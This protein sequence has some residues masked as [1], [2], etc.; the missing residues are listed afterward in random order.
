[1]K[2]P[3][4][5]YQTPLVALLISSVILI[6]SWKK[7]DEKGRTWATYKGDEKSTSYAPLDQINTSNVT[8]LQ[9][10]WTFQINDVP[11]GEQ[12]ISSQS[13]PIIIDGV[14]YANSGKQWVYALD[15]ETGKQIWAF[16]ALAEGE[17]TA[18]SRGVTYWE[19][20]RDKRILYS[21]GNYVM[22]INAKT[23]KL[24][25][26]FGENGKINLNVGVRDDPNKISVTLTT[27]GRIFNDLII[28]GS[29]LPDFYGA[30][31]GYIRAYHCKTGKL[32]WTFHTIP[33]PGEVGYDTWPKDA[34]K[35]A[36][37]ANCWAG[38]SIDSKRGMVFL[39]LGSPTYDFYGADRIGANLFGNCGFRRCHR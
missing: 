9:N 32:V 25:K 39:A 34:Y 38:M 1:M 33:H 3:F 20:G 13:N 26:S 5:L 2:L 10:V 21:A 15:A 7:D 35:Y 6:A 23:G 31:P 18:A 4:Q 24:I 28:I 12:P 30:A 29:R 27:P 37:G 16:N 14:M 19:K 17:P 36:G 22:A 8:Q 11:Q